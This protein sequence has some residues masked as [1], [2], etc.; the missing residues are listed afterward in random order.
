ML[1]LN[2]TL[3]K[4]KKRGREGEEENFGKRKFFS[5]LFEGRFKRGRKQNKNQNYFYFIIYGDFVLN[6]SWLVSL[7]VTIEC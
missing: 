7:N 5:F 3:E 1:F 2:A 6:R 4:G